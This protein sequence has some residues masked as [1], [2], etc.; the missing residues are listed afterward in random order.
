MSTAAPSSPPPAPWHVAALEWVRANPAA[1]AV[2]ASLVATIT[3][4]Y[5]LIPLYYLKLT[6]F[7][8]AYVSW[9]ASESHYEHGPLVP[10]IA[11]GLV[12]FALPRL[13]ALQRKPDNLGLIPLLLGLVLYVLSART[14]QPRLALGGL[15]FILLGVILYLHGRATARLLLFPF[16]CLFFMIPVPGIDALP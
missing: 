1:T 8:W 5:G 11:A 2:W 4:F 10:V 13:R 14:L 9:N 3:V 15:P 16:C 6:A 12:W 7:G